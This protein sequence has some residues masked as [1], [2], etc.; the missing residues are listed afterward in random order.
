MDEQR[1]REGEERTEQ[2]RK[3]NFS[4]DRGPDQSVSGEGNEAGADD[5]PGERMSRRDR[6]AVREA[7]KTHAIAPV[8]TARVAAGSMIVPAWTR[9]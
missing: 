3:G 8:R 5:G 2:Q 4:P 7:K 1:D 6:E 9:P